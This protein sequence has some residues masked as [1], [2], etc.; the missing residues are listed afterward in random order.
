MLGSHTAQSFLQGNAAQQSV[1]RGAHRSQ[2]Q[3]SSSAA[4]AAQGHIRPHEPEEAWSWNTRLIYQP[5]GWN[6][7]VKKA[8]L[9]SL[10]KSFQLLPHTGLFHGEADRAAAEP[11]GLLGKKG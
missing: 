9:A 1:G 3:G 6:I 11:A 4:A 10:L 2:G 7:E 8:A 5:L